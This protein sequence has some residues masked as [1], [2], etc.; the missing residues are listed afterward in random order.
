MALLDR[1]KSAFSSHESGPDV[2]CATD[3]DVVTVVNR[4]EYEEA[5]RDPAVL[6]LYD[7]AAKQAA[8]HERSSS[9]AQR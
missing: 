9:A 5:R 8:E 4:D 1:I 6:A 7:R 3:V 2:G